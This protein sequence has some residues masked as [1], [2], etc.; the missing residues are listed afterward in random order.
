MLENTKLSYTNT[1]KVKGKEKYESYEI[2]ML[3][4]H[5]HSGDK[6]ETPINITMTVFNSAAFQYGKLAFVAFGVKHKTLGLHA[7]DVFLATLFQIRK[8]QAMN[9]DVISI[10]R[11][12]L[13]ERAG[14]S[15]TNKSNK[16]HANKLLLNKLKRYHDAGILLSIPQ[17]IED[18][19]FL[20]IR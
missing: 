6:D 3:E 16:S 1:F 14:L 9:L 2:R 12:T 18:T 5:K 8:N 20:K 10:D 19:V 11:D 13:I 4:I 15:K 17:K 7:D